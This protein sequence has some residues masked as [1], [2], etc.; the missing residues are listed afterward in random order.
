MEGGGCVGNVD[1]V[2]DRM[3]SITVQPFGIE[4][5]VKFVHFKRTE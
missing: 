5:Y 1:E 2:R 3:G 4:K